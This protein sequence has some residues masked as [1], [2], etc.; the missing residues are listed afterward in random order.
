MMER[1]EDQSLFNESSDDD[2]DDNL[3]NAHSMNSHEPKKDI[4]EL[5]NKQSNS[6]CNWKPISI[7]LLIITTVFVIWKLIPTQHETKYVIV[8]N[9][10]STPTPKP[11]PAPKKSYISSGHYIREMNRTHM[12][13]ANILNKRVKKNQSIAVTANP[14]KVNKTLSSTS[15]APKASKP[16]NPPKNKLLYTYVRLMQTQ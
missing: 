4:R 6:G 15:K 7:L 11:K 14:Q 13:N 12:P 5:F 16:S 2:D 10:T 8:H 3:L 1:E 9:Q